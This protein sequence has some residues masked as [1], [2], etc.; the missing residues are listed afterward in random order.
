MAIRQIRIEGDPLLRKKSREVSEINERI[1]ELLD[2]M[3]D[4]LYEAEGLGLAAPQVGVLRRVVVVDMRDEEGLLM[5]INP[6]IIE[7]SD[8]TQ[9]NI[10]GCLSVPDESGY[11]Q[12][13]KELT[14]EY[15]DEKGEKR[16]MK[17]DGYKAV[18]ISHELDHLEGIL[19]IDKKIEVDEEML[20]KEGMLEEEIL[21]EENG[22]NE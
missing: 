4:T 7:E 5:M 20:E 18:C 11:V 12:R 9:I 15:L 10:E 19:Y 16:T 21:E 1:L 14:V 13:P 22:E 2:D 6:K 3:K 17:C 8:E